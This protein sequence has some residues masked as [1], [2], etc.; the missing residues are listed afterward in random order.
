MK[1][2]KDYIEELNTIDEHVRIE[3]KQCTDKVDKSV[4]ESI[5]AFSNEPDLGGGVIIIGLQESEDE[6]C[7]YKAKGIKDADKLQ[8]DLAS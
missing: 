6:T 4:L 2:I 7:L 1:K 5:C 3:A 8:R